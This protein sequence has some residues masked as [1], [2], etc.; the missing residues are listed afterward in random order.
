MEHDLVIT[1]PE[2]KGIEAR[3]KESVVRLFGDGQWYEG[4]PPSP[5]DLFVI[6]LG[7][8]SAANMYAFMTHRDIP[9]GQ[10]RLVLRRVTDREKKMIVK[11][12][13]EITLPADFPEKYEK[14]IVRA[15]DV[16]AVKQHMLE[17][18]EFAVEVKRAQ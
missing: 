1:F 13:F 14:A 10:A 11:F 9:T 4:P 3:Y 5:F 18:P 6:G 8:C 16:C 12:T 17:P 7:T 15:V 2:G